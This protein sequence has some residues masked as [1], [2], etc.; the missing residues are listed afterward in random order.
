MSRNDPQ[1]LHGTDLAVP[2]PTR[3]DELP[4][5]EMPASRRA[6]RHQHLLREFSR[7]TPRTFALRSVLNRRRALVPLVAALVIVGTAAAATTGWLTGSPAPSSVVNGFKSYPTQLGFHPVPGQAVLVAGSH[8]VSLYATL[9][10]EG[11]YCLTVSAPWKRPG[12]LSDGG[13]C[14]A[15]SDAAA[16]F[17][18]GTLG[19][20][21][22]PG[23]PATTLVVAGR[24]TNPTARAVRFQDP[25]GVV[26]TERLGSSGFFVTT[27]VTSSSACSRG[28]WTPTFEVL[29]SGGDRLA[30]GTVT[31]A[32]DRGHGVCEFVGP[33]A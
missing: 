20:S 22:P 12:S 9:N 6:A 24:T 14:V 11:G 19:V 31:R 33:H 1:T 23:G 10:R 30:S 3:Y 2:V 32:S 28:D 18:A 15:A 27:F 26:R 5:R 17:V 29:A 16:A 21:S 7:S 8:G 25:D 4:L 13:T